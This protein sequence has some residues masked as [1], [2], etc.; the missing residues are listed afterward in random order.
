Y[1]RSDRLVAIS[2]TLVVGST[3][4]AEQS[5]ASILFY[6]RHNRTLSHFGGYQ[7]TAAAIWPAGGGDA[8]RVPGNRVTAGLFRA[9][10]IAPLA[11]RL[12]TDDDDRPGAAPVAIVAERLWSRKYGR[13]TSLLN[14]RIQIDGVPHEVVGVMPAAVRFPSAE[15]EV[16][17]PMRLDPAKTESATF[18]YRAIGRL[19]DGASIETATMDLQA[20]L[21]QLPAEFPGRMTRSSIEQ[22]RMRVA[23]SPLDAAIVGDVGA[24]LWIALGAAVFV[25]AISCTN[26]ASLFLVRSEERRHALTVQRALGAG[27]GAIVAEFVS[28]A[29]VLSTMGL[30]IGVA[31]SWVGVRAFQSM[32]TAVDIPRLA[33][34]GVDATVVTTAAVVSL[35]A[36]LFVSLVP[37]R[38]SRV[39]SASSSLLASGRAATASRERLHARRVLVASQV[40]LALVLLVGAGLMARSVS[41]LRSVRPGIDPANAMTFRLALPPASYP[42]AS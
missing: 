15:T 2:H 27:P 6:Q 3:L 22:T 16:W 21:P 32:G 7:L 30:A 41:R 20:L 33:E 4:T 17:L 40:A 34:V 23:L 26:V 18:D 8:G 19:R 13:D 24:L 37:A 35:L 9:V 11:G 39:V 1:P 29:C 28:E 36:A 10:P 12:F 42:D 14:R 25:L 38:G 5:D 31:I